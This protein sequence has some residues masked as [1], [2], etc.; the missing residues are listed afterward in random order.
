MDKEL[1]EMLVCINE[2]LKAVVDNQYVLCRELK[3]I[4]ER[5]GV[6]EK[7]AQPIDMRLK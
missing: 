1:K 7:K 4:E 2:N 5:L 6:Y 3:E